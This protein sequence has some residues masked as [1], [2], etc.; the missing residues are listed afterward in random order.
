MMQSLASSTAAFGVTHFVN[1][2]LSQSIFFFFWVENDWVKVSSNQSRKLSLNHQKLVLNHP[3]PS[4][5]YWGVVATL[6]FA[7]SIS[8]K[9]FHSYE[10]HHAMCDAILAYLDLFPAHTEEY[11]GK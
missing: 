9:P 7:L 1:N 8:R 10:F 5:D 6:R 11:F 2:T 3:I 4:I